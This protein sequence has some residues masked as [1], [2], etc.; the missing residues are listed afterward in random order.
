VQVEGEMRRNP[1]ATL[2]LLVDA[3]SVADDP[4]LSFLLSFA[5]VE[6]LQI[7][8]NIRIVEEDGRAHAELDPEDVEVRRRAALAPLMQFR[9]FAAEIAARPGSELSADVIERALAFG[10]L[11][12]ILHADAVITPAGSAFVARDAGIVLA[13]MLTV[14]QAL[15]VIGSHVRQR[16]KVP[17]GGPVVQSR[18]EV[19]PLT[20]R[21]VIPGGEAF[22]SSC[23]YF[24]GPLREQ[25]LGLGAAVYK[26][27]GQAMR[28]RDA[29]HESLRLGY[30]R[31]AILD[32]LYHLDVVLTSSVAAFDALA[33]LVHRLFHLSGSSRLAKWH[34]EGWL[35]NLR[36]QAPRLA[37]VVD[38]RVAAQLRILTGIR[39]SIHEIPLDE[40]LS[41]STAGSEHRAMFS[42]DLAD[43][44]RNDGREAGDPADYGLFFGPPGPPSMNVGQ[45]AE[46]MLDWG[47]ATIGE[48]VQALGTYPQFEPGPTTL[49][50]SRF[51]LL[52]R[53]ACA[54]LAQVGNYPC[55]RRPIGI[56]A[57][58]SLHQH[59]MGTLA[60]ESSGAT[61][62]P[63]VR[64]Y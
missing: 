17:L 57:A 10:F 32:S 4:Q 64:A 38:G 24:Q 25:V 37:N 11:A 22:W 6:G 41:V 50:L 55:Q 34:G 20:A 7:E 15:A 21:I 63:H 2:S 48:L 13:P 33:R 58:P 62:R 14:S 54:E 29:V 47:F 43:I 26:R 61:K 1:N 42:G 18:S 3:R 31:T 19:Y 16:E 53:E 51:E 5:G 46:R 9:R 36:R 39:N 40:Y 8:Q 49:N 12:T 30:G 27:L 44:V 28:G 35:E 60:P 23:A 56:A 45:F 52:E 59:M